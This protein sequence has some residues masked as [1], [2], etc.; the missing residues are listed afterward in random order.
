MKTIAF[1]EKMARKRTRIIIYIV[2]IYIIWTVLS[3]LFSYEEV[4]AIITGV[5]SEYSFGHSD[6]ILSPIRDH[7]NGKILLELLVLIVIA[8]VLWYHIKGIK[9]ETR[10]LIEGFQTD[11]VTGLP[12]RI[13]LMEDVDA[14]GKY[15]TVFM[16]D[17]DSFKEIYNFYG[18][19]ISDYI[20]REMGEVIRRIFPFDFHGLYS[21]SVDQF[22]VLVDK[23]MT[24][25]E[26]K[27]V[28]VVMHNLI[29][30]E[31][32]RY[33]EEEIT[34]SATVSGAAAEQNGIQWV[35]LAMDFAKKQGKGYAV[36]DE[37]IH[38]LKQYED[39]IRWTKEIRSAIEEDR[40]I[41]F[42]QPIVQPNEQNIRKFE[43]LVRLK[44]KF[45]TV[46][47]PGQFL[48]V[49]KKAKMYTHLTKIMVEKT[50]ELFK[51]KPY[52]FSINLCVDD[53]MEDSIMRY[54]IAKLD[55]CG[56]GN[57]VIFEIVE[58]EDI[59][60]YQEV[61]GFIAE[62]KKRGCRVAIDDFGTGYSNFEHVMQ[63]DVD[64]IKIDGSL[65]KNIHT[66]TN[67]HIT[68]ETIL[69][70]CKKLGIQTI[71]EYVHNEEVLEKVK[72]IGIDYAQG[73]HIGKPVEY[74]PETA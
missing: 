29:S 22:I 56:V 49:A 35:E 55:E 13:K 57:Q 73:F 74:L 32:F 1:T 47:S 25:Q 66:C 69:A 14:L 37:N 27:M 4:S 41:P 40:I 67:S 63:M 8:P 52:E 24:E 9:R 54:I 16:I 33:E 7:F 6:K 28:V 44:D 64:F 31:S 10:E 39:N 26:M 15:K 36:Y 71:G 72:T 3:S 19:K 21:Y 17:I 50:F 65:I 51:G 38:S 46:H 59:D 48:H 23:P 18:L 12:N 2:L 60:D 45:G 62:V 42:F 30:N 43:C 58:S 70:F 11:E 53:I 20:L 5:E 68:A 34:L 61:R